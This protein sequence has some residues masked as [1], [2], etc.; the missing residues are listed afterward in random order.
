[1]SLRGSRLLPPS[2]TGSLAAWEL[3]QRIRVQMHKFVRKGGGDSAAETHR[4]YAQTSFNLICTRVVFGGKHRFSLR[5]EMH[6]VTENSN[7]R[8]ISNSHPC[9]GS[10]GEGDAPRAQILATLLLIF[11]QTNTRA[12]ILLLSNYDHIIESNPSNW[13]AF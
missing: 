1:M 7:R 8:R 12:D 13:H 9:S 4:D 2:G 5:G 11:T 6:G 10:T 3:G